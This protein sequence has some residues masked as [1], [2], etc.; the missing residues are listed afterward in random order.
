MHVRSLSDDADQG[1]ERVDQQV[2]QLDADERRDHAAEAVVQQV[3][4]QQR[5]RPR[6]GGT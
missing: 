4:P 3:P 5:R 2:D 1:Q 6:P